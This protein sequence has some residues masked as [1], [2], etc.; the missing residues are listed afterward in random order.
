[1]DDNTG[2]QD[3]GKISLC[4]LCLFHQSRQ[5]CSSYAL[6]LYLDAPQ[7]IISTPS[8]SN[9]SSPIKVN[10]NPGEIN[11][12]P[13]SLGWTPGSDYTLTPHSSPGFQTPISIGSPITPSS[14]MRPPQPH[15]TPPEWMGMP[16][17]RIHELTFWFGPNPDAPVIPRALRNPYNTPPH[18]NRPTPPM[19]E[20]NTPVPSHFNFN[21]YN[22]YNPDLAMLAKT[23]PRND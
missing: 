22:V 1:M 23:S 12:G 2:I 17:S 5:Y 15:F 11:W 8:P 13:Y 18:V 20:R 9:P 10:E 7:Q 16:V 3:G 19:T 14:P 4:A 6:R 21:R